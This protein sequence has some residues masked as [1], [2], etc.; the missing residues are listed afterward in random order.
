[1]INE[2]IEELTNCRICPCD[3][4]VNRYTGRLGRCGAGSRIQVN[5][6]QVHHGEEPVLSGC[7]GSGTIFFSH[8]NL[9]CHFCQNYSISHQGWGREASIDELIDMMIDLERQGAHNINFVTPTHYTPLIREAIIKAK[10]KGSKI[11]IVWNSNA[12]EKVETLQ[13]LSGLVD[14]YLP[15]LKFMRENAALLCTGRSDYP[16]IAGA[17]IK[18]MF[19]Q[20][21][22]LH[23]DK[24]GIA[25]KGVLIRLLVLPHDLSGTG[26]ALEW[27][28]R[29]L[30]SDTA[31]SLMAQYYPAG[32]AMQQHELNRGITP[33]EYQDA[34]RCLE[35]WGFEN[36]FVQELSCS[37][38]WTPD[39][40]E[41]E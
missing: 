8:C 35:Y 37:S 1:M 30:G 36:G 7:Q 38:Q 41:N 26:A 21:G 29:E 10:D 25:E 20:A 39:F 17:A 2:P 24:D 3:C 15:D 6:H 31:I 34:I 27:I 11:P 13:T 32:Q 14:I 19:R 40:Q 9:L 16:D 33:R 5:L 12:Y 4:G 23:V 22:Y 28:A 18:E